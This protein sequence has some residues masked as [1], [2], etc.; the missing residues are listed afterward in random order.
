MP[1]YLA[2]PLVFFAFLVGLNAGLFG[3]VSDAGVRGA[4]FLPEL[5]ELKLWWPS[6]PWSG[7][8]SMGVIAQSSAEIGSFCGVMAIALLLDVSSLEV[9]RQKSG[10]LDQEFRSNGLANLLASVLG[11]FGGSLSMNACL[12]LDESGAT[13]RWAGAIV[14]LGCALILFSGVDVGATVPKAILAGML[15]YLGA[16][17]LIELWNAPPTVHGWNGA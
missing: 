14:G 2:L 15:I 5:G 3:A 1:A 12:L 17:I 6:A 13:T 10:D 9:A 16:V 7:T 4:W 11:G 8:R